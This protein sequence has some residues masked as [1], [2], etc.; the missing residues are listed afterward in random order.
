MIKSTKGEQ[1][2]AK[3]IE[4][5]AK[6]FLK[7]GYNATGINDILA[8]TGLPKGSFYFHFNSK[9]AL[10]VEV[11]NYFHNQIG[12]WLRK[13]ASGKQWEE[14]VN[15]FT[16]VMLRNAEDGTQFGCPFA[17]LGLELAYSEPDIAVHYG[18]S[19]ND[20][21]KLFISVLEFSNINHDSAVELSNR[22]AAI[23]EGYLLYYRIN[24]DINEFKMMQHDLIDT[25][26]SYKKLGNI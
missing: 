6:L 17:V 1:S 9:K 26:E 2:K 14:F 16:Q 23:Y 4:C 12:R 13:T 19:L 21:K 11:S 20:L 22:M 18:E 8:L 10:A 5:A 25:F 24:K 3:L 7:N 15:D